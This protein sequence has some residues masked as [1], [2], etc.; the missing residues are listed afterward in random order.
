MSGCGEPARR[1]KAHCLRGMSRGESRVCRAP[2]RLPAW[3]GAART[4][5]AG[6]TPAFPQQDCPLAGALPSDARERPLKVVK[7]CFSH[8]LRDAESRLTFVAREHGSEIVA[9][10]RH[11]VPV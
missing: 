11:V 9:L 7:V 8:R 4:L 3:R 6:G 10:L 5:V 2:R 1:G